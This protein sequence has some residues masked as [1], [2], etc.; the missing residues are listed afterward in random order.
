MSDH[1]AHS[2]AAHV[3]I[4]MMVFGA[5][6]VL[7]IVTVL[8]SYLHLPPAL[9]ILIGLAIA[10]TKASL[11]ATFFMHLKWERRLIYGLLGL[12]VFFMIVLFAV[13]IVDNHGLKPN[14]IHYDQPAAEEAHH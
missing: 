13:P 2:E 12:T 5:L 11:V 6:M 10:T 4:Y 7:T 8:V 3:K 14:I 1:K 9:G